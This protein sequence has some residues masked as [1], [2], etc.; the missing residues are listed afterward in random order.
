MKIVAPK[1]GGAVLADG[2]RLPADGQLAGTP[3]TVFDAVA[4]VLSP[5]AGEQLSR[6]AAAVD[7]F[8]D[9]F[10]HLKAIAACKG[11]QPILKAAGIQPDAGVVDPSETGAFIQAASTRQWVREPSVRTLA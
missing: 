11:S 3:S 4:S 5:E 9:A 1:V 2:S 8:R 7:W 10:G 6:E